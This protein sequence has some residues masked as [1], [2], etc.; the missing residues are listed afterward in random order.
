[1]H[2][3]DILAVDLKDHL[4]TPSMIPYMDIHGYGGGYRSMSGTFGS[5]NPG[6]FRVV[7]TGICTDMCPR[8]EL[9]LGSKIL[10]I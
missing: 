3:S 5:L 6:D 2:L 7:P 10:E 8:A 4:Y 9:A 1:M